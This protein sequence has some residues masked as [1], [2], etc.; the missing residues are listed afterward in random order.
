MISLALVINYK[1]ESDEEDAVV[2]VD[3]DT[4]KKLHLRKFG[5]NEWMRQMGVTRQGS[6]S[7]QDAFS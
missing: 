6:P 3:T 5:S 4:I 2:K 1:I 7:A